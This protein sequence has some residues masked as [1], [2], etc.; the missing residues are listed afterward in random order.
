MRFVLDITCPSI[1]GDKC[2][3]DCRQLRHPI[4]EYVQKDI[5]YI[6]NDICINEE[7][8]GIILYGINAAGKSS[9]MKSLGIS[10][11]MAQCGM[12][13]PA[14]EYSFY[15]YTSIHTRILNNDNL[16]KKQST[17]TVEMSEIRN[18]LNNSNSSSLVIGDEL[19]SGTESVSAISLVTAGVMQLAK[20]DTSFIFATH[21]HEPKQD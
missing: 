8:R 5:K 1:T 21:L 3:I 7:N 16:Y 17:F 10:V 12:Y 4:I 20:N 11:L 18:I 14:M 6:P 13:V 15:P 19:C 9:L 2:H